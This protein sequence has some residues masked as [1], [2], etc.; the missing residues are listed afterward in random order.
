MPIRLQFTLTLDD[1][2]AA[3]RLHAKRGWWP[4]LILV[5][6]YTLV[7]FLGVLWLLFTA[8]FIRIADSPA[9][10]VFE[11]GVG[12]F[13]VSFPLYLRL[14]WKRCYRRTRTEPGDCTIEF[15][16]SMIRIQQS[17]MRSEVEWP[18]VRSLSENKKVFLLYLAAAK[19]VVIPKR[20]CSEQQIEELHS[21]FQQEIGAVRQ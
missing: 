16:R 6:A 14:R 5:L 11:L 21:L 17:K 19:F 1:Y 8:S 2:V 9:L 7:P 4:R 15:D 18:A 13:L 12:L 3:Q 10:F 20:I